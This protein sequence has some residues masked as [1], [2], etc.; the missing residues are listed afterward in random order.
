MQSLVL[1]F[2]NKFI[3]SGIITEDKRAIFEFGL[4]EAIFMLINLL[5][6]V[7]IGVLTG[8]FFCLVVFSVS[9]MLLHPFSGG[10]HV[11]SRKICY[12]ISIIIIVVVSFISKY[13]NLNNGVHLFFMLI[14]TSIIMILAPIE[15]YHKPLDEVEKKIYRQKLI[16]RLMFQIVF[17]AL[18]FVCSYK[19]LQVISVSFFMN[20]FMLVIGYKKNQCKK[21]FSSK[22]NESV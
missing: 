22:C 12:V 16:K 19:F 6:V 8:E 4:K 14:S 5:T 15:D 10:Y 1:V 11:D 7:A 20:A 21:M 13:V 3:D 18:C 9:Y 2:T 17:S